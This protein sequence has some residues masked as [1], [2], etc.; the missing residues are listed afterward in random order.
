MIK[1]SEFNEA[2]N[3]HDICY[4]TCHNTKEEC[5]E[6]FQR[7]LINE[8]ERFSGG[9]MGYIKQKCIFL[10]LS[11]YN[12]KLFNYFILEVC[13]KMANK[14]LKVVNKYGCAAYLK[15]QKLGCDCVPETK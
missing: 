10:K 8:C 13:K 7:D 6:K 12:K 9:L 2:C 1:L 15:D 11:C 3:L 4:R 14:L 5:D